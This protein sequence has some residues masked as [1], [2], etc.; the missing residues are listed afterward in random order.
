MRNLHVSE[1]VVSICYADSQSPIGER[2]KA[3]FAVFMAAAALQVAP[4]FADSPIESP[5]IGQWNLDVAS[6]PMPL[7]MRPKSVSLDFGDAPDGKW[8]TRVEIIEQSGNRMH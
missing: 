7:E 8:T 6:L 5:L 4:V 3:I 1:R 2:M